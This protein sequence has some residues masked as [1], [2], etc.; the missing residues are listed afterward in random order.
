VYLYNA[1]VN[2]YVT[3]NAVSY[4]IEETLPAQGYIVRT[5]TVIADSGVA[6][7]PTV[8]EGEKV[9]AG[10]ALAVEYMNLGA[11]ETASEIR[12]LRLQL[13]QFESHQG[14][15]DA[16]AFKTIRELSA[17][18]HSRDLSKL[19]EL[20]LNVESY[21][22]TGGS[23]D[24]IDPSAL[25]DR[26]EELEHRSEGTRIINA[27]VS[28]TFSY[29]VDGFE[30]IGPDIIRNLAPDDLDAH[31]K[32]P[33][34]ISGTGKLV[35]EFKWYYAAIMDHEDAARL[36]AG[37]QIAVQ[38]YG[39]YHAEVIMLVESIGKRDSDLCVVIFSS[40]QGIHDIAPLRNLRAD[41]VFGTISG[42]RVPKEAIHLDDDGTTF[43]YLQTGVRAERV[44]VEIL[45]ETGDSYLVRDGTE[46]NSPLR[47][48][49]LIIVKA[50]NLYH[51]KVVG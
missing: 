4:S 15:S 33:Y 29:T 25:R 17:A 9:A 51:G 1:L 18:V 12:A 3:T 8:S 45:R 36:S 7:L 46:T 23:L 5:E 16:S 43:V 28:G 47:A 32:T 42:I 50:N 34:G 20:L 49:S 37:R 22:F 30:H 41:I 6:V 2:T 24:Q 19:D 48:D 38:F 26:L 31:F 27:Q 35:T 11:L 14:L 13:A 40:D 10:Q 21:I 39:A 44:N